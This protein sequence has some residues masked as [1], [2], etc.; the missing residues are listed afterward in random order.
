[1]QWTAYWAI[2][3]RRWLLIAAVVLLD[4]L[5]SG[6][7]YVR[8]TRKAGYQA[9]LTLYVA[10]VSSPSTISAPTSTL[11]ST[12][13]L[14]S[15]ETAANFFADDILDVAQS[16]KVATYVSGFLHSHNLPNSSQ[17]EI[18][19]SVSG[20]RRDR[21]V[22]LCVS[23]PNQQT[24]LAA[25]QTLGLAMTSRRAR[26]VGARMAHRTFVDVI[27]AT[28]VGRVAASGQRVTFALRVVL[29]VL[30]A[31]GTA[32]LWDA[33]DPAVRDER[34]VEESLGSPVLAVLS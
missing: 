21:T 31:L 12:G 16:G 19:G 33:L 22:N 30:V 7:L 24:A 1:M 4:I 15:G 11:E 28:T 3:R 17:G 10:D 2:L 27:S 13:V 14:L 26:F 20:S 23:N 32:L 8:A 9:C 5:V 29:G 6:V 25:A 34:D 18:D